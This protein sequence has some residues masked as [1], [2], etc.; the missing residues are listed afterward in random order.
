MMMNTEKKNET[1]A[2]KTVAI[3]VG[4][5]AALVFGFLFFK[6]IKSWVKRDD[7]KHKLHFSLSL[8]LSSIFLVLQFS[9]SNL[10]HMM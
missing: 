5:S 6:R 7:G 9:K 8:S 10:S 3:V 1:S 2:A 4:A